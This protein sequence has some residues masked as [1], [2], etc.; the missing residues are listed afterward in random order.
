MTP[1][2]MYNSSDLLKKSIEGRD[3]LIDPDRVC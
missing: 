1:R 2:A 3:I